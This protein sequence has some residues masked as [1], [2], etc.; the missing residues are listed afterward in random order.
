MGGALFHAL[1]RGSRRPRR[2]IEM[3]TVTVVLNV[4]PE[5]IDAFEAGFRGHELPVWR[6]ARAWPR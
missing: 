3:E 6:H 5:H 4:K 1:S 2:M